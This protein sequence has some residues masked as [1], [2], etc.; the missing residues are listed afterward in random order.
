MVGES[1]T[2]VVVATGNTGKVRELAEALA[3][4]PFELVAQGALGIEAAPET[5]CTFLE[6]ALGKARHAAAESGLPAI[7]DDSGLVVPALGGVPGIHSARFAGAAA[8]DADNNA[9]LLRELGTNMPCAA[10]F[11]CCLIY[12]ASPAD[13]API[14]ATARWQG[15]IISSPRGSNGFGYDPHFLVPTLGKT[16]AQLPL[17]EKNRLSHRG[18]ACRQ[19]AALLAENGRTRARQR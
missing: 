10:Y 12:I 5:A 4:F 9:K 3:R 7:A 13:P 16:S 19:L 8:T 6:N 2:R 17:A 11:T 1:S 15:Q 18:Q 14:V